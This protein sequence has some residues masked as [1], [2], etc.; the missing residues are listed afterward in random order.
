MKRDVIET[1][2]LPEP[3]LDTVSWARPLALGTN[4]DHSD[5]TQFATGLSI[6]SALP[7]VIGV[8]GDVD[9]FW[10]LAQPGMV[11]DIRLDGIAS[12]GSAA[13]S[14]ARVLV[15]SGDGTVI[16]SASSSAGKNGTSSTR[17]QLTATVAGTYYIEVQGGSGATGGYTLALNNGSDRQG[18]DAATAGR[19]APGPN[20]LRETLDAPADVDRFAID[21]VPG[22]AYQ[23]RLEPGIGGTLGN[24]LLQVLHPDGTELARL[25][26]S[27][28]SGTLVLPFQPLVQGTHYLRVSNPSGLTGSYVLTAEYAIDDQL[29]NIFTS[30]QVTVGGN[31]PTSGRLD[32][33]SDVDYF[34]VELQGGTRY[35]FDLRGTGSQ[36]LGPRLEL[37]DASGALLNGQATATGSVG[38]GLG[39]VAP[40]SG[41]YYLAASSTTGQAGGYQLRAATDDHPDTGAGTAVA[42][43]TVGGPATTGRLDSASDI[44]RFRVNLQAGSH[45]EFVL[46]P[47]SGALA[48]G[49]LYLYGPD[50]SPVAGQGKTGVASFA[51]T[52]TTTGT[53]YIA[54]ASTG[55]MGDYTLSA[56][57]LGD[58]YASDASTTGRVAIN[59]EGTSGRLERAG[60]ID[61][62]RIDLTGGTAYVFTAT[63]VAYPALGQTTLR[64]RDSA[65]RVVA[66]DDGASLSQIGFK[67]AAGGVYYLEVSSTPERSGNYL[68]QALTDDHLPDGESQSR[69]AP[70]GAAQAG[71]IDR[72]TDI[73]AFRLELQSGKVYRAELVLPA[74]SELQAPLLRITLGELGWSGRAVS[75]GASLALRAEK[76][77]E[78]LLTV[79]GADGDVG[80][81]QLRLLELK[82]DL[83]D[84]GST[85]GRV[86]V[87]GAASRGTVEAAGDND[88]FRV[89]LQA[90]QRY[91]F[92]ASA[93][94]DSG[95]LDPGL[96]VLNAQGIT[97]ANRTDTGSKTG[98]GTILFT[99]E[100]TGSYYVSVGN[101]T[102]QDGDYQLT[103]Q[104]VPVVTGLQPADNAAGVRR[105]A[106]LVLRFSEPVLHSSGTLRIDTADGRLLHRIALDDKALV[107]IEGN[108][109]TVNPPQDLPAGT[110][111]VVTLE[112]GALRDAQGNAFEGLTSQTDF[113]FVT[114]A[115]NRAPTAGAMTITLGA[116]GSGQ[117][118]LPAATDA[119]G[120]SLQYAV[121]SLPS[122]GE[123]VLQ[124]DGQFSFRPGTPSLGS[125]SFRYAVVDSQGAASEYTVT[126]VD[127]G[128]PVV[129]GTPGADQLTARSEANRYV[130]LAGND[131]I[132]PGPGDDQVDGG[133]GLDTAV[134]DGPRAAATLLRQGAEWTVRSTSGG[135]DRLTGVE[136]LQ[137][138]DRGVALDLD[139]NAGTTARLIGAVFGPGHLS[140]AALVGRYL[141]L[142]DSG[143]AGPALADRALADALFS[144]LAGSHGHADFVRQVYHNV[145]GAAPS[146]DDLGY[147]VGL[148]DSGSQTQASLAWM[149]SGLLLTATRIDLAGLTDTG[150]DYV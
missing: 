94:P 17:L 72:A 45:Y 150:L 111:I 75:S 35:A 137:F 51:H 13:L 124:P 129:V 96:S 118:R 41:T 73:D 117:G 70:G 58:D 87:D 74:G 1:T 48:P 4:D 120:D 53:Y 116:G 10:T 44:D 52:A 121:R 66:N 89:E 91:A 47:G 23:F 110:S 107:R 145:V 12:G 69:L 19:F 134:L 20:G 24:S 3:G 71:R 78:H 100:T 38:A 102:Y 49:R 131:R 86:V 123:L 26:S 28:G 97:L 136:R 30:G 56:S 25:T 142:A 138:T 59:G 113:N 77:G 76:S 39:V 61:R 11:Y 50:G 65:G 60:D 29:G 7:G 21:L 99:A 147:F 135:S 5:S 42:L 143:L 55:G 84:N 43:V 83:P 98:P 104:T 27:A 57:T 81:Y 109:V 64:L 22:A 148:L 33:A 15:R 31:P 16:N 79:A 68:V 130:A 6:N 144:Q 93:L 139:G 128:P 103:V 63:G 36:A 32:S 37:R 106:D 2:P 112:T 132:S 88:W 127:P 101:R 140:D 122:H 8:T 114:L 126:L 90:G 82:D 141:A 119:D 125:T 92:R 18:D 85:A 46:A 62:F 108:T 34:R 105:S 80:V 133:A 95:L 9:T 14:A 146:A 67:P 54:A 115:S 149:A 40:S